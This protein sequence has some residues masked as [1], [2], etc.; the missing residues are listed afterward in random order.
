LRRSGGRR[1]VVAI[2]RALA[3]ACTTVAL[4][5]VG[6]ADAR[7][8]F[9]AIGVWGGPGAAPGQF[10]TPNGI[11][12]DDRGHVY[13]A[14]ELNNRVQKFDSHGRLLAVLGGPAGVGNGQFNAPYGVAIDGFGAV[15]VADT[16][17]NRIQKFSPTGRFLARWGRN[18]GDGSAGV[19]AGEFNSPRG[20]AVDDAGH[21]WVADHDNNRVVELSPTGRSMAR[22]GRNG[23]DGT[24]GTANGEFNEPRGVAIDRAGHVFVV[25]KLN[26]RV[27]EFTAS[28]RFI[29]RWGAH[30][31]DGTP[32]AGNG[33]FNVP[34]T[35]AIDGA[36]DLYVTDVANNRIQ[37]FGPTGRFIARYGHNGG[38]GTPGTA[39]GE[40]VE[41]YGVATDCRSDLYVT[42]EGTARVQKLGV[43]G[44]AAPRCPPVAALIARPAQRALAHG[45]IG[46]TA[47]CDRPCDITVGAAIVGAGRGM[48]ARTQRRAAVLVGRPARLRLALR[49]ADAA[50]LGRAL[51]AGRD[52]EARV[53]MRARGFAG[54]AHAV[55]RV[56]RI[57][58]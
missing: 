3:I 14:D 49:R 41:P 25:E 15:Y 8:P 48:R 31:G 33:E 43:A 27:Q 20:V 40:F 51:R 52:V 13:V 4:T 30:G 22:W 53:T 2:R 12:V 54:R 42:E 35:M 17:N 28:G 38:D 29:R 37:K 16:R 10:N 36:G 45:G 21:V 5:L 39:L 47:G 6:A 18:G 1:S 34:Y 26:H 9:R 24:A 58:R 57:A 46:L 50:A 19:G 32:G 44:R 56:V 11:A 7:A 55:H 23:G